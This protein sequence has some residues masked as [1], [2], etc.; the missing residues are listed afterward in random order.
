MFMAAGIERGLLTAQVRDTCSSSSSASR[1]KTTTALTRKK[2]GLGNWHWQPSSTQ[3][4]Q[5]SQTTHAADCSS[6]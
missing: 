4:R 2:K 3:L 6:Q 1:M 5:R